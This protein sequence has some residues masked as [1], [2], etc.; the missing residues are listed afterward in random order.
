MSAEAVHR[1]QR[2]GEEDALSEI[3]NPEYVSQFFQHAANLPH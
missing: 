1:Q 3:G 2:E